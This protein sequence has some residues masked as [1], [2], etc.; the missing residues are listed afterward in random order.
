M[1]LKKSRFFPIAQ[2]NAGESGVNITF[3]KIEFAHGMVTIHVEDTDGSKRSVSFKPNPSGN[4]MEILTEEGFDVAAICG[5][6]A[7]CGTCH[8]QVRKGGEKLPKVEGDEEFMID[9]LSNRTEQSRL[10]CQ[11]DLSQDMD[12]MDVLVLGDA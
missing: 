3:N 8:I 7:G 10:S 5:G 9:S 11:L 2:N 12:G 1:A 4:L 6:M